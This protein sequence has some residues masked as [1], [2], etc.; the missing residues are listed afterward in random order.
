MVTL[1][2]ST[3]KAVEQQVHNAGLTDGCR[4]P[5]VGIGNSAS[6]LRMAGIFRVQC[7][8]VAPL[9]SSREKARACFHW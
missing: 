1:T 4:R 3:Q 5:R 9:H 6:W 8:L 7:R 2:N